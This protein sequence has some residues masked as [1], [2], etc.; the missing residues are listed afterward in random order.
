MV[1]Q[2]LCKEEENKQGTLLVW[3]SMCGHSVDC[4]SASKA[5]ERKRPYIGIHVALNDVRA[6]CTAMIFTLRSTQA[7]K[8]KRK[9]KG[10]HM[11]LWQ[12]ASSVD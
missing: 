7:K 6:V 3:H 2:Q 8:E 11:A 12:Y 4:H 10:R 5:S 9:H 1:D